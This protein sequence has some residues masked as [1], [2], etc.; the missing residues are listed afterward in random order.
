DLSGVPSAGDKL[1]VVENEARARE[2]AA[3][4]AEQEKLL[5]TTQAPTSLE[6]MFSAAADSAVEFPLLVKADV[7][8]S[9]EA[10]VQ[11]LNKISNDDIKVRVLH[12]GVGAITESDVI[13]S[14]ERRVGKE[15]RCRW[16]AGE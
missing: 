12:S 7:Q 16:S 2:V 4:R 15:C 14:E 13:R 9:T 3:Y 8:G 6:N 10:I 5:R 1:T 11:A